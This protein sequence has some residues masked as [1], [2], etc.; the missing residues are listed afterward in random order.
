MYSRSA[1][2]CKAPAFLVDRDY[3][4]VLG[5]D[6][7]SAETQVAGLAYSSDMDSGYRPIFGGDDPSAEARPSLPIYSFAADLGG[8]R[9][10]VTSTRSYYHRWIDDIVSQ[11]KRIAALRANWDSYGARPVPQRTLV[12]ALKVILELIH[13][14]VPDRLPHIG[15]TVHGGVSIEWSTPTSGLEIT[16]HEPSRVS[17]Y[18]WDEVSGEEWEKE[19]GTELE[20]SSVVRRFTG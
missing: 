5:D 12:Y 10:R 13:P 18:F 16:V 2:M 11:L 4:P 3:R 7:Y 1:A 9:V 6:D 14:S 19:V 17:A 8:S 15:A 20:L